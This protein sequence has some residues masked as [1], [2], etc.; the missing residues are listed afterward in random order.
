VHVELPAEQRER[1]GESFTRKRSAGRPNMLGPEMG[2]Y[3]VVMTTET[4]EKTLPPQNSRRHQWRLLHDRP[5]DKPAQY[6]FRG[7]PSLRRHQTR[8]M[9]ERRT[10]AGKVLARAMVIP[11][12]KKKACT[13]SNASTRKAIA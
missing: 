8:H 3:V 7:L 2:E 6:R 1:M 10:P 9:N 12:V 11:G 13:W 4:D 5:T